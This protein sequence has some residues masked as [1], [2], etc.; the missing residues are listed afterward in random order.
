MDVIR[1]RMLCAFGF[2]IATSL[3]GCVDRLI[4]DSIAAD[5]EYDEEELTDVAYD[6]QPLWQDTYPSN[7]WWAD[8]TNYPDGHVE[9]LQSVTDAE[10]L[11]EIEDLRSKNGDQSNSVEAFLETVDFDEQILL[12]VASW[13][14][15]RGYDEMSIEKLASD[16]SVIVGETT[17]AQSEADDSTEESGTSSLLRIE[18][19]P[20]AIEAM[21][22]S[23]LRGGSRSE[24]FYFAP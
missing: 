16:G 21:R 23:I 13:G 11:A 5:F 6:L 1:R 20:D 24:D 8:G 10:D 12:Y 15:T 19:N 17:A 3:S 9:H 18:R 2:A 22:I 4:S 14:T 7:F